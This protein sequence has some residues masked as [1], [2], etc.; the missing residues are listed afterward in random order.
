VHVYL[1]LDAGLTRV[2]ITNGPSPLPP[3]VRHQDGAGI[4]GMTERAAAIGGTLT[5]APAPRRRV[6]GHRR[7]AQQSCP[8]TIRVLIADD[9]PLVRTGLRTILEADPDFQVVGE[10]TVKTHVSRGLAKLAARDR[11]QAIVLAYQAGLA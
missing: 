3:L 6:H 4:R 1:N 10:A 8:M 7:T 5:A 2:K 9:Q 11:I